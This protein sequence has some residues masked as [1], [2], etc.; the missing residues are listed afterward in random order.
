LENPESGPIRLGE[1][2]IRREVSQMSVRVQVILGKEEAA[3][4]R[5]QAKKMSK[6]LSAWLRDAGNK[7]IELGQKQQRLTEPDALRE[8]FRRC[9]EKEHGLEPDWQD[10]K[11][12]ILDNYQAGPK[13]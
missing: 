8:F 12:L 4:F 5:S 3:R 10:H 6:S 13:P 2:G 1:A 9:D 11:Q 7:M